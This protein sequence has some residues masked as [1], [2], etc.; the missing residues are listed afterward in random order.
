MAART[1]FFCDWRADPPPT[2]VHL[3]GCDSVAAAHGVHTYL[4]SWQRRSREGGTSKGN[5]L[6]NRLEVHLHE[7]WTHGAF[8]LDPAE[9]QSL[10]R[11]L[12]LMAVAAE[13]KGGAPQPAGSPQSILSPLGPSSSIPAVDRTPSTAEV[14]VEVGGLSRRRVRFSVESLEVDEGDTASIGS[15]MH[16]DN[17]FE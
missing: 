7:Q 15:S 6:A 11:R 4:R 8:L 10:L 14:G 5:Q 3:S 2:L 9:Q 1:V 17:S 12:Q 13:G 16:S